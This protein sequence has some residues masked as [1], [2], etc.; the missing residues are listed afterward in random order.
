MSKINTT[1]TIA[2][3]I[4]LIVPIALRALTQTVGR[5]LQYP[6]IIWLGI[7][8]AVSCAALYFRKKKSKR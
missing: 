3:A 6:N 8:P 5:F 1:S 2:I 4:M 7:I